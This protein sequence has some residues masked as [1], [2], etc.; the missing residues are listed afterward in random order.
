MVVQTVKNPLLGNSYNG[1]NALA[2][3]AKRKT[4]ILI[5]K[6][7]NVSSDSYPSRGKSSPAASRA[8]VHTINM[9]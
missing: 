3:F 9:N 6:T 7:K 1:R 4:R 8:H 2:D 5:T